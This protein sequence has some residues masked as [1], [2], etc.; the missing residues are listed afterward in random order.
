MICPKCEYEYVESVTV[1]PDCGTE[2]IQVGEFE[3]NL[4][5]PSDWV[6]IF[7]CEKI[8]EAEMLKSNLEGADIE[9]LVLNQKDRSLPLE[10][11]LSVIKVLVRK[12]DLEEAL[13][14]LEDIDHTELSEGDENE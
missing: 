13:N 7:T 5:H 4:V 1:C 3:G 6:T 11:D 12:S 8:Y 2:L 14:I 10:G 9:T